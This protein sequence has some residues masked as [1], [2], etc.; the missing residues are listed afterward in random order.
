M[1]RSYREKVSTDKY[2]NFRPSQDYEQ[3]NLIKINDTDYKLDLSFK[4]IFK[5]FKIFSID[6]PQDFKI[7]KAS[8]I[9]GLGIYSDI[10]IDE[11]TKYLF[12]I[13][14]NNSEKVFDYDLDFKY[15]YYDFLKLGI[16]LLKDNID[17]IKFDYILNGLFL[18]DNTAIGKVIQYRTYKAPTKVDKFNREEVQFYKKK[19]LEYALPQEKKIIDDRFNKLWGY[20]EQ[21]AGENNG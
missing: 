7:K 10:I 9:L 21:K 20:V 16:D 17:W 14:S 5:L 15:Y 6:Y 3:I 11:I 4:N 18:V 19:K 8:Q 1:E 13:Q 12:K 2:Y